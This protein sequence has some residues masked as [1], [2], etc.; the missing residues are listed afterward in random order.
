[1]EARF[2]SYDK[3]RNMLRPVHIDLAGLTCAGLI[4]G[5]NPDGTVQVH[6]FHPS[7][8]VVQNNVTLSADDDEAE[9]DEQVEEQSGEQQPSL[10]PGDEDSQGSSA[11][12]SKGVP[13][14]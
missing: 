5:N 12:G 10:T 1:M 3:M 9:R 2:M 13:E 6:A 14:Q 11:E 8:V 4:T 7:G